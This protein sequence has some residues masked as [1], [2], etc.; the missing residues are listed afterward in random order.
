MPPTKTRLLKRRRWS[1]RLWPT[2]RT[3]VSEKVHDEFTNGKSFKDC[4]R[5]VVVC[6]LNGNNLA[7]ATTPS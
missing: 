7:Q 2:L 4:D 3:T 1:R 5:C 6:D